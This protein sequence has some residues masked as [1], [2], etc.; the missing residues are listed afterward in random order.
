MIITGITVAELTDV[1][2]K[3]NAESYNGNIVIE[4]VD[5]LSATGTRI[6][7]KLGTNDSRAH[8]SRRS[9]SGRHGKYLCWHG[10]RDVYRAC[11]AV[12]PDARIK[13]GQV[14][15]RGVQHFEDTYETTA[16]QNIGSMVSPTYMPE[17]CVGTC[18]GD[19]E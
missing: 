4:R 13:S 15:Y 8:G 16:Y 14:V 17:C 3:L 5:A 18:N 9:A 6:S 19:F 12:N 1:V 10:F 11:F 7:A 2:A